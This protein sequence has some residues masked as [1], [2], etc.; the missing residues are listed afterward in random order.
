MSLLPHWMWPVHQRTSVC[1]CMQTDVGQPVAD[2][3]T[4]K[5]SKKNCTMPPVAH[6]SL[7]RR[8]LCRD[9]SKDPNLTT[10]PISRQLRRTTTMGRAAELANAPRRARSMRAQLERVHRGHRV[11]ELSPNCALSSALEIVRVSCQLGH[12]AATLNRLSCHGN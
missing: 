8:A 4:S 2:L 6:S 12:K 1:A 9:E 10:A 11:A 5:W 7:L 3:G